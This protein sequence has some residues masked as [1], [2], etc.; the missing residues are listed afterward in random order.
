LKE[1]QSSFRIFNAASFKLLS[2]MQKERLLQIAQL[3]STS[4]TVE[5]KKETENFSMAIRV[6]IIID[7]RN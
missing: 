1:T 4:R 2:P 6:S 3:N 7:L 5:R